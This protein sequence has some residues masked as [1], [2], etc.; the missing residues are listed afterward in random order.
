MKRLKIG[1]I[2][3]GEV[4]QI[5]HLPV[6]ESLSD[7]FETSAICD[8]SPQLLELIGE[9]YRVDRVFTDANELCRQED[10]DAVLVL[11]SDEYHADCVIA[12][13]K[14]KK[15]VLVEKPMC[16]THSEANAIIDARDAAGVHVMVGYMRRFAPAFV[17]AVR[18]VKKLDK[19]NF[20]RIRDII[21]Q[22]HL[23]VEQS[24]VVHRFD[25][26]PIEAMK[27][28]S[29]R[30]ERL[31]REAIGDATPA[32]SNAYR[33]LCGLNSHDVSAMREIIGSPNQ[34]LAAAQWNEGRFISAIF[35]YD[36][37]CANLE[38][39][40]DSQRR[41]DAHIEVYGESKSLKV[42]Y[43][44]PYIRH[45]PTT[46]SVNETVDE[47]YRETVSR[48][49]Y[50]DPYSYEMEHFYR[51]VTGEEKPKTTPEDFKED[52]RVFGMIIEALRRTSSNCN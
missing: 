7:R 4:A 11:S 8:V 40:I 43:D 36:G 30:A 31:V 17:E 49:T 20:V 3:I 22:N 32:L 12:A 51:V 5:V 2:G 23:I 18:E 26:V 14:N 41:F 34:V 25:D 46:L 29:T 24:S 21:G 6:L 1:I 9:R 13:A 27:D 35:E 48:P 37:Y 44:T 38:T 33:L 47:A 42:Q 15:H 39:G 52:L 50:K 45:L 16:L 10:L 28:R 19:I